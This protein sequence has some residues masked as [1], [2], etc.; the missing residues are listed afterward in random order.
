MRTPPS[1]S[2]TRA[3]SSASGCWPKSSRSGPRTAA[4]QHRADV[5]D[6]ELVRQQWQEGSR[7]LD[8]AR[9]DNPR[10]RDLLEQV[11][12]VTAELRRRVGQTFTLDEL[13]RAYRTSDDW[14][15]AVLDEAAPEGA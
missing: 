8:R 7:R 9:G 12:V 11:E 5:E 15:R 3:T 13:A 2:P 6:I 14:A 1:R 4:V 10:F